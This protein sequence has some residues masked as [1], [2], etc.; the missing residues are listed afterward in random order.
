MEY[1]FPGTIVMILLFTAIF[2]T[3]SVIEDR[4]EGFLQSVLVSPTPRSSVVLGKLL[5]GTILATGQGMLFLLLAPVVGIELGVMPLVLSLGVMLLVSFALTGLGFCI[6]WR[7]NSTHG[8]HA[9]MNLFLM[10]MWL[11]SGAIFPATGAAGIVQWVMS[12]NPLTYGL[13]A[14][15]HTLY[16]GNLPQ[17][18][19]TVSIGTSLA[20]SIFF[21]VVM[22]MLSIVVAR[23]QEQGA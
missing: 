12:I 6:A 10:P 23:G 17:D 11:L 1:F 9:I 21:A 16:W 4:R 5:G 18:G 7:M 22:F 8:F 20:V 15:R 3:I 14:L 19:S 13:S 2:S